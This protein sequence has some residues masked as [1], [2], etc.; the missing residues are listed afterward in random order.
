M[1]SLA[2]F[3]VYLYTSTWVFLCLLFSKGCGRP[4]T[5][6]RQMQAPAFLFVV[7]Q[8]I[9][10][11]FVQGACGQLFNKRDCKRRITNKEIQSL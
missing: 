7:N 5:V 1:S 3:T 10:N 9:T 4:R 8:V 2:H 6:N 11:P